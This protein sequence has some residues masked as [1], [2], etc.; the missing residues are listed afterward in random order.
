MNNNGANNMMNNN[1]A[2]N[3]MNNNGA[4]NMMNNNGANNNETCPPCPTPQRCPEPSFECKKVPNYE[5]GKANA[6][7]P[8]PI[9]TDFSTFGM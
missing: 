3:M 6:F 7:L 2:N 5:M 4:N 8:R 1:G 9:L